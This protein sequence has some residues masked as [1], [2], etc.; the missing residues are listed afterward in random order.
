[1]KFY[2][3]APNY[4][5]TFPWNHFSHFFERGKVSHFFFDK[6]WH[7]VFCSFSHL[8]SV[9]FFSYQNV[10]ENFYSE[11]FYCFL[12]LL[13]LWLIMSTFFIIFSDYR[14]LRN[15][16]SGD[17]WEGFADESFTRD[18][19]K[20][21]NFR[22]LSRIRSGFREMNTKIPKI[23]IIIPGKM[24]STV[25]ITV[26]NRFYEISPI[27][28]QWKYNRGSIL[29]SSDLQMEEFR[30]KFSREGNFSRGFWHIL[31]DEFKT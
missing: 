24:I 9:F 30:L 15:T 11:N 4:K 7:K 14:Q 31:S 29:N 16:N 13:W 28:S 18:E 17:Q 21:M 8:I 22:K 2:P 5:L 20:E 19:I 6:F 27:I 1:M 23:S 3:G 12:F 25:K 26:F 10:S